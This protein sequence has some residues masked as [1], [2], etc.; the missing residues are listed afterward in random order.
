MRNLDKEIVRTIILTQV[1]SDGGKGIRDIISLIPNAYP[2]W[3]AGY[4]LKDTL[5]NKAIKLIDQSNSK[6]RY[7]ISDLGKEQTMAW[8]A[9]RTYIVYFNIKL[10]GHLYQVSFHSFNTHWRRRANVSKK[11]HT[12]ECVWDEGDSRATCVDLAKAFG[13]AK[14]RWC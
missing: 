11:A 5:I 4:A 12:Y 3:E 2:V 6:I 1:A 14:R 8:G 10:E 13:L 9:Q 7:Y